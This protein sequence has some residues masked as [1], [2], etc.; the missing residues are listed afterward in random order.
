M[1]QSLP[2]HAILLAAGVGRRLGY[3]KAALKLHGQWMLP[4]LVRNLRV[5]GATR[6]S[7]VLSDLAMDA[8]ADLGMPEADDEWVNPT[9][10]LGR[11]GSILTAL[12]AVAENH[13]VMIHCCDIPLLRA[14][15][16]GRMMHA[17]RKLKSPHSS[18]VRPVSTGGR[19][20]HP[21]LIGSQLVN[22][23]RQF[24]PDQPLRELLHRHRNSTL[25]LQI[26]DDP[27]PFI[28]VNT[29]EQLTLIESLL[30]P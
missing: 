28:D 23:L 8:I 1:S 7:L 14:E 17:W 27:G 13:A 15:V 12:A 19:G 20:G 16:V 2:V 25:D 21:L 29:P 18:L 10:E 6:V 30:T 11:T 5:G 22:E 26:T 4:E 3:P 9:P 24:G